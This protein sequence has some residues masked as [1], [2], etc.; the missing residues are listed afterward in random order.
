MNAYVL[1]R[2]KSR[3]W[4]ADLI[5]C[6]I[7]D[8]LNS[9]GI[10]STY[11]PI[12]DN[13][14]L[15][16]ND[17]GRKDLVLSMSDGPLFSL[18][19]KGKIKRGTFVLFNFDETLESESYWRFWCSKTEKVKNLFGDKLR[20]M[21]DYSPRANEKDD[22]FNSIDVIRE[23]CPLGYSEKFEIRKEFNESLDCAF[24]GRWGNGKR[25][26]RSDIIKV[27]N[28]S[29]RV[30]CIDKRYL[31]YISNSSVD[32]VD[33]VAKLLDSKVWLHVNRYENFDS[34][35]D[36]RIIVY[37]MC[38]KVCIVSEN[39]DWSPPFVNGIHWFCC[40]L[41]DINDYCL[42]LIGNKQL[43]IKMANAA[44]DFIRENW[45]LD[46]MLKKALTSAGIIDG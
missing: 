42:F 3:Y 10:N 20:C 33:V 8:A 16:P 46:V 23:F 32:R 35:P 39:V 15:K 14:G 27:L 34:F 30:S 31:T 22:Y 38:N 21:L 45:R 25:E 2:P 6:G 36:I 26:R 44:Y 4:G 12:D 24:L 29:F 40:S 41:K 7:S 5:S 11:L 19:R 43:R 9:F 17:I 1:Y 28:D 13:V 18:A 37:G